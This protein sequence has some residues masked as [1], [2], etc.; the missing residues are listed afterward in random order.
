MA[1]LMLLLPT[2]ATIKEKTN[3]CTTDAIPRIIEDHKVIQENFVS[4]I[5]MHH[6]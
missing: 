5:K 3:T 1:A 6:N 2:E 4:R